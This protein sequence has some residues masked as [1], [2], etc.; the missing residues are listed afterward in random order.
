MSVPPHITRTRCRKPFWFLAGAALLLL[1]FKLFWWSGNETAPVRSTGSSSGYQ[2]EGGVVAWRPM[3]KGEQFAATILTLGLAANSEALRGRILPLADAASFRTIA[4]QYG[5]DRSYVWFR[6]DLIDG[7]DPASF[8]VLDF[9]FSRDNTH[10]EWGCTC[11]AALARSG[12]QHRDPF[13]ADVFSRCRDLSC[14]RAG[15]LA[16]R[17]SHRPADTLLSGLVHNERRDLVGRAKS[18]AGRW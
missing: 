1:S 13:G 4:G 5:L 17:T 12:K 3:T 16:T 10:L 14:G 9:G 18:A 15:G 11:P 7:A 8:E 2:I 6:A